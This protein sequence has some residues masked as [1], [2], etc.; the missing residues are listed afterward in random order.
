V[1]FEVKRLDPLVVLADPV[2][3]APSERRLPVSTPAGFAADLERRHG[4]FET[5]GWAEQ[6]FALNDGHQDD[7][8]FLRD[9]LQDLDR[10]SGLLL[11]EIDRGAA[12]VFQVFTATD[13]ALHC[14]YRHYDPEHPAHVAGAR[15]ALGDPM[16]QVYARVDRLLGEVRARLEPDDLL[17]V[18]SDHGFETWR[19]GVNLNAWLA[20]EGYLVPKGA[21][22][23]GSLG[24][25]FGGGAL[26][27]DAIDWSRTRAFAMGL[28]QIYLNR[29]GREPEGIVSDEA[30]P[31]LAREI[32]ERLLQL[33]NPFAPEDEVVREVYL[34]HDIY[35]G[36]FLAE[37]PEIQL[38][39]APGYRIAWQTALLSDVGRD[40]FE[41]N[42][43]PWS[44]DHCSTDV[45]TV[46]GVLLSSRPLPAAPEGDPY[47]VRDVAPTV[48]RWFGEDPSDLDGR[49]LPIAYPS[50]GA[51]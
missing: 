2:Q 27:A 47:T 44:G 20:E 11:G 35:H 41:E 45:T 6:T 36:P 8:G 32:R 40:V 22:G 24:H 31:A 3:I 30:A 14:F 49:P 19:W 18:C 50:P 46:P 1:R 10:E 29:K 42:R 51:P 38:G 39:F 26:G 37:A 23:D 28:G 25:L 34:L 16:L 7:A 15:E 4:T 48:L 33:R 43:Y 17:L 13:R 5:V 21:P 12:V 9:V